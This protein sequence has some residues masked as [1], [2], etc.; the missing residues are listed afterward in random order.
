VAR[1]LLAAARLVF[2]FGMVSSFREASGHY[3]QDAVRRGRTLGAEEGKSS[4]YKTFR[5]F[6]PP[7]TPGKRP[8]RI[9]I[10]I[11]GSTHRSAF[12]EGGR[13]ASIALPP[14][15]ESGAISENG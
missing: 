5:R 11:E 10:P 13:R 7:Y 6:R 14:R 8:G 3:R 15:G 1:N 9:P 2:I 12:R 4:Q